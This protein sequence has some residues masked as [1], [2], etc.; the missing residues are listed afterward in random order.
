MDSIWNKVT[1]LYL[2]QLSNID[3]N[4]YAKNQIIAHTDAEG[5]F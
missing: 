3:K 1:L 4:Y 2:L 5:S